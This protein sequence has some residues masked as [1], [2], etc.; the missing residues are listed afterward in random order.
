MSESEADIVSVLVEGIEVRRQYPAL[1][2]LYI[3]TEQRNQKRVKTI[4]DVVWPF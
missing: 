3:H 1:L 4:K 2:D